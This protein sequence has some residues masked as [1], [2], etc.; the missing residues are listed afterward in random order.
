[1][2]ANA[3]GRFLL[4][5]VLASL[6][7]LPGGLSAHP[8]GAADAPQAAVPPG[9]AGAGAGGG[10]EVGIDPSLFSALR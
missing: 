6:M 8:T 2:R 7:G 3:S 5:V 10:A 4:L 9:G 1:M